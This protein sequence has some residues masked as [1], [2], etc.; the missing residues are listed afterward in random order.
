[1][2]PNGTIIPINPSAKIRF[3]VASEKLKRLLSVQLKVYDIAGNEIITV[4]NEKKFSGNYK[5]EFGGSALQT[6]STSAGYKQAF[7]K[8]K[9]MVLMR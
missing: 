7:F 3:S 8:T 2:F 4:V 5:I 9:R 1:M 6:V